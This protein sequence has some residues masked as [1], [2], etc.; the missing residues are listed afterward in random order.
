MV[1]KLLQWLLITHNKSQGPSP[2]RFYIVLLGLNSYSLPHSFPAAT[3]LLA[4]FQNTWDIP[5][6]GV[7]I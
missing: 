7:C 4:V 1:I 3:G 5:I 2:I 6:L